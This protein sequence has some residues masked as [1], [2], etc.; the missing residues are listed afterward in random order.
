MKI[1]TVQ[2]QTSVHSI[3]WTKWGGRRPAFFENKHEVTAWYCQGCSVE[4][5]AEIPPYRVKYDDE[6]GYLNVCPKC[7]V[8]S[9]FMKRI[10]KMSEETI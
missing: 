1:E 5:L 7:L 8:N 6:L 2:K 3:S 4:Q 10:Y 9:T